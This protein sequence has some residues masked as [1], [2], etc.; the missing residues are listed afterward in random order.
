MSFEEFTSDI[1]TGIE[2]KFE[3]SAETSQPAIL[4]LSS[5][6]FTSKQVVRIKR[7]NAPNA[8]HKTLLIAGINSKTDLEH[9]LVWAATTKDMLPN[10]EVSDL[11]LLI[12]PGEG[13]KITLEHSL[14]IE[15]S[16]DFC[17]K[18]VL[19][20][21]ETTELFLQRTFI[22][23]LTN[24]LPP[25]PMGTD[26]LLAAAFVEVEKKYKWFDTETQQIWKDAFA[27]GKSGSELLEIIFKDTDKSA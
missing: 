5:G 11:Y 20:P 16:E 25:K 26:S 14:R 23:E 9:A 2:K 21:E 10:P 6:E 13:M 7:T 24:V 22:G 18:Y 27:S 17:R 19:R 1:K 15:S 3:L 12:F 8:L 4:D